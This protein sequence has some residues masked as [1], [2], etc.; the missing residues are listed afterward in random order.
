MTPKFCKRDRKL[1]F[2]QNAQ[3]G[4]AAVCFGE[5][6]KID[7]LHLETTLANQFGGSYILGGD[8]NP[9]ADR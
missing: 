9:P 5:F 3:A 8:A 7:R 4:D 6:G 2:H 1:V